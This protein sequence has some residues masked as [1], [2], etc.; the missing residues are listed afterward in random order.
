MHKVSGIMRNV[1]RA[2]R[3]P[4]AWP[5][6]YPVYVVLGDGGM[7]CPACARKEYR[8]IS[9]ATRDRDRSGWEAL[10]AEVYWEGPPANCAH[11]DATLDSAYGDP[12]GEG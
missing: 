6:G 7:L 5:G 10:G 12:N 8:Q 3:Q 4:Y 11:C 1:R 9:T 2:I